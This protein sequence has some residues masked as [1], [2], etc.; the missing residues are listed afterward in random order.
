[1][2]AAMNT[3][4]LMRSDGRINLA[5]RCAS[6]GVLLVAWL[7]A[8]CGDTTPPN[9]GATTRVPDGPLSTTTAKVGA[10][11]TPRTG[12]SPSPQTNAPGFMME[13]GGAT[14]AVNTN[15]E[16]TPIMRFPPGLAEDTL[17]YM[18]QYAVSSDGRAVATK[19]AD[20]GTLVL[21]PPAGAAPA[22]CVFREGETTGQVIASKADFVRGAEIGFPW[23]GGDPFY[24]SPDGTNIAFY[25]R[26]DE[27]A[28]DVYVADL[29]A[30]SVTRVF[31]NSGHARLTGVTW[32]P[33]GTRFAIAPFFD[34]PGTRSLLVIDPVSGGQV[35]LVAGLPAEAR[36]GTSV[37][38]S[39]DG[40]SVA[41]I[42]LIQKFA[43]TKDYDPR[44]YVLRA[45]GSAAHHVATA[46]LA[47]AFQSPPSW[48]PDGRWLV[49][50]LVTGR[51]PDTM[52][53]IEAAYLLRIDDSEQRLLGENMSPYGVAWATDGDHA[54][55]WANSEKGWT[56]AIGAMDSGEAARLI[57][58]V[59]AFHGGLSVYPVVAA[60]NADQSAIF[61]S[62]R[63]CGQGG[64]TAGPLYVVD[65]AGGEPRKLWDKPVD[66]SWT[67][68]TRAVSA[69]VPSS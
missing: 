40:G 62:L 42:A 68:R 14:Y 27:S 26:I 11:A 20:D 59:L 69:N 28:S 55:L 64:C 6:A 45:D 60:W 51:Y 56:F 29:A 38:W 17:A 35:D 37:A 43:G 25:V 53:S 48:S 39:P 65:V 3:S 7:A 12:E 54:A 66:R 41:V 8:A 61:Y 67:T 50:S 57:D 30:R 63:G 58:A 31:E 10:G 36:V 46:G 15:G 34:D 4:W 22:I 19:C 21:V 33:D 13:S 16:I 52:A 9:G 32:S 24:W 49:A 5:H 1:M 44:I 2:L 47:P 23:S 18:H